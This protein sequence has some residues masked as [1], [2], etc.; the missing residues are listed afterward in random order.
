MNSGKCLQT[1][2]G[3]SGTVRRVVFS[4]NATRLASASYDSTV[5]I[6]DASSGKC[7][8][9]LKGHSDTVRSVTFSHDST[10]LASAS[11]DNTVKVWNTS[12][13]ACLQTL[14]GHIFS[15]NSV[16]FSRDSSRLASAS[17]DRTIKTWNASS[18]KC[19][20]TLE[21]HSYS[22]NSVVFSRDSTRLASVSEDET[23]K[24][25]DASS[26]KCLQNFHVGK[27]LYDISFD[28]TG[29]YLHTEIGTIDITASSASLTA[30]IVTKPQGPRY[31]GWGLSSDG[32][33]ITYD[34]Q[35]L[36]WLLSEYR[37]SYSAVSAKT[38]GIGVGSGKVLICN[39]NDENS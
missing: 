2:V 8:Q 37:P 27:V 21:G 11:D 26:G 20:Q 19:L 35:N 7:L 29:L 5:K 17:N 30:P 32:A 25:W 1:L 36:V 10:R 13:G 3:H 9:T 28:A 6:W 15:V 22:V 24:I 31:Q 16:A 12:S 34:S 39:F 18:G 4:Y 38:I 14:E 23:V 33:W